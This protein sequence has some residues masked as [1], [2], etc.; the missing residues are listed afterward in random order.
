MIMM[1][2]ILRA[3]D[4]NDMSDVASFNVIPFTQNT[5]IEKFWGFLKNFVDYELLD[6]TNPIHTEFI[7]YVLMPM[8]QR[9]FDKLREDWNAHRVRR[10]RNRIA[11]CGIP[12]V[13]YY[14]SCLEP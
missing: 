6:L 1:T 11:S 14:Q 13:L 7:R 4:N 12:N 5:R 3:N 9:D 2:G 10:N 8:I